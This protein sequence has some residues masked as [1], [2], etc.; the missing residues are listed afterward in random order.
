MIERV[1]V[2]SADHYVWGGTSDGW[3]L[4]DGEGLS[5]IEERVPPGG[6]EEW[7][8]HERARQFFYVLEGSALMRTAEGDVALRPGQGVEIPPLLAH[9]FTNPGDEPVRFLV[10]STPT[11]RGDRI[12]AAAPD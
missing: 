9:R 7:H 3:R 2:S 6:R 10:I 8:F 1:D 5:V 4:V 12:G 11:T